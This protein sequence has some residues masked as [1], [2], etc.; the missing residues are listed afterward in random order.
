MPVGTGISMDRASFETATLQ[1]NTV[2]LCPECGAD[3]VWSKED[4]PVSP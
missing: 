1:N 4:V 2:G 3:H